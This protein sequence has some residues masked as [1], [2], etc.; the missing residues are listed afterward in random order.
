MAVTRIEN[1]TKHYG[2]NKE[3]EDLNLTIKDL[4]GFFST[5][6]IKNFRVKKYSK[7]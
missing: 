7:N 1:L 6:D 5:N 4:E 2:E 3:N